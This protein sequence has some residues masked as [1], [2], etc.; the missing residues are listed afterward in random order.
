MVTPLPRPWPLLAALALAAACP[1]GADQ[2]AQVD[3]L[4]QR[5]VDYRKAL[6]TQLQPDFHAA[7]NLLEAS[8]RG[9][10]HIGGGTLRIAAPPELDP[11]LPE[12]LGPY[13]LSALPPEWIEP[14]N[15]ISRKLF[16]RA[17]DD[18]HAGEVG[19]PWK[20]FAAKLREKSLERREI[21]SL[22][23]V[24]EGSPADAQKASRKEIDW[25]GY[26]RAR[27]ALRK[28][29][30]AIPGIHR[31][32]VE[33]PP[34]APF[35]PALEAAHRDY[36]NNARHALGKLRAKARSA[37]RIRLVGLQ[38]ELMARAQAV[39]GHEPTAKD[40]P[41]LRE[42]LPPRWRAL[43]EVHH[44]HQYFAGYNAVAAAM[45]RGGSGAGK[46]EEAFEGGSGDGEQVP[47]D[48][49][50]SGDGVP[51]DEN[52]GPGSGSGSSMPS[53]A[54]LAARPGSGTGGSGGGD[55]AFRGGGT[56]SGSSGR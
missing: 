48:G 41:R 26:Q 5:L 25:S 55:A 56:G 2:A 35:L 12:L 49:V 52:V 32:P 39:L 24:F 4:D 37:T 36:M 44:A 16:E 29:L 40:L 22:A 6:V 1:A 23:D 28:A 3:P 7:R 45:A 8:P 33:V 21:L 10:L 19:G 18:A 14:V 54:E 17:Q 11:D 43:L 38:G 50:G 46:S 15:R 51:L 31:G 20:R 47:F 13:A 42:V 27:A 30:D 9:V 53:P 34:D